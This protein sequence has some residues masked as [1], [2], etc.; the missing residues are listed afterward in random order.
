VEDE[1]NEIIVFGIQLIV[2]IAIMIVFSIGVT[3]LLIKM[4]HGRM[5]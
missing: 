2:L 1:V 4:H 3:W 5:P